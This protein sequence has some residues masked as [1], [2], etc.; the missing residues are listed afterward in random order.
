MNKIELF[1]EKLYKNQ[2]VL[3]KFQNKIYKF[4]ISKLNNEEST[5]LDVLI[6]K[7]EVSI[8]HEK[9]SQ[10]LVHKPLPVDLKKMEWVKLLH[11]IFKQYAKQIIIN[12]DMMPVVTQNVAL[13]IFV[14]SSKMYICQKNNAFILI[15]FIQNITVLL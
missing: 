1:Y 9:R 4:C 12:T 14:H 7:K 6:T 8:K 11:L 3:R 10:V 2:E 5:S 15:W 13:L